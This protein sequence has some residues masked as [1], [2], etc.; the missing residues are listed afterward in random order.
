MW[1]AHGNFFIN[2]G[3]SKRERMLC[4]F[5]NHLL[6]RYWKNDYG[7]VVMYPEG[8]LTFIFFL[9]RILEMNKDKFCT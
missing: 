7:W 9:F 4:D 6:K 1:L 3:A 2:G 5:K 8:L